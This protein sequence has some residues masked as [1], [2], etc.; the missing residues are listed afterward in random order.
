MKKN[1]YYFLSSLNYTNLEQVRNCK[2]EKII[3]YKLFKK[4]AFVK[5]DIPIEYNN[6]FY[7]HVLLISRHKGYDISKIKVFPFFVYVCILK[8]G[9]NNFEHKI[10]IHDFENIGC[11]E[12]YETE[13][14][15]RYHLF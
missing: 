1:S 9:E 12:L 6:T 4:A 3:K 11:A 7:D 8:N 13:N 5:I 10:R 15:A 14:A 2:I